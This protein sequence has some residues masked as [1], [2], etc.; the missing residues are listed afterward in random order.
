ME[1]PSKSQPIVL[2]KFQNLNDVPIFSMTVKKGDSGFY[3]NSC[4]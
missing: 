3:N 2:E 4:L 1:G